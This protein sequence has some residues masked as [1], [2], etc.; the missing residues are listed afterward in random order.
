MKIEE[1]REQDGFARQ[2]E[3]EDHFSSYSY[4]EKKIRDAAI[5]F[6]NVFNHG[7]GGVPLSW[8]DDKE[9][10]TFDQTDAHTLVIGPTGSKK[11]RLV[12]MPLV[13]ILGRAGESMIICDP[14]AEIYDRLGGELADEGY[15]IK[16]FNL[17]NPDQ[18]ACWNPLFI[19]YHF[20]C[21]GNVNKA[22][23]FVNDIAVN[24]LTDID[25]NKDPFWYNSASSLFFGLTVFLFKY[26]KDYHLPE[27]MVHMGN[28]IY[29]RWCL[30]EKKEKGHSN[31]LWEYGK[32]D[33]IIRN[34]L[35]GTVETAPETKAGILS[36]FD[37][38]MQ[39]FS[40]QPNIMDLM[41]G[42]DILFEKL[43]NEKNAIFLLLPDE[44]T[45]YH[46][47]V[48][49]IIKQSYEYIIY[50]TQKDREHKNLR[51]NY[52]LDE[53]SSLPTIKDFPA[54]ISAARSRNIRFNLFV[55]SKNQLVLRY[56]EESETIL[57]NCTNWIYLFSR[58]VKFLQE[59][60]ELCGTRY[61]DSGKKPLLDI[62]EL[63]Q[64]DKNKGDVLLLIGR[65]R[66]YLGRLLD[67]DSYDGKGYKTREIP[68]RVNVQREEIDFSV[69]VKAEK[70]KL[71]KRLTQ[72]S[73]SINPSA[74]MTSL[75]RKDADRLAEMEEKIDKLIIAEQL[76]RAKKEAKQQSTEKKG[77]FWKNN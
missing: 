74:A 38:R 2:E 45:T 17:R 55:Q 54:M 25:N 50:C 12:A 52:V 42:N 1:K 75:Q 66:P 7:R 63:Q 70:E 72:E 41:A 24:L 31:F 60:S 59:I 64:L 39:I 20:Y 30:F 68:E 32:Q 43:Q 13:K 34:A 69:L 56:S 40:K 4:Q 6:D 44:K 26:C 49:L 21:E 46:R 47:L 62:A 27:H 16:V 23:E 29:L 22:Y 35:V 57:S 77:P 48:A 15:H 19:P 65:F 73:Q 58:E 10:V 33:E 51:I 37:E 71:Q 53:F 76:N 61:T 11:S 9:C 3:I 5:S 18:S 36:V 8:N 67:I 14:K 28:I